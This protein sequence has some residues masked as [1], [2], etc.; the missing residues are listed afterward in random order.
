MYLICC[1]DANLKTNS[2]A[3]PRLFVPELLQICQEVGEHF[4]GTLD[5][6]FKVYVDFL[7]EC[8]VVSRRCS[9]LYPIG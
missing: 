6:A 4:H 5:I 9:T 8:I 7:A 2:S 1:H 3:D